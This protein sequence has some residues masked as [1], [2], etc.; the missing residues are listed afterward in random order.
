MWNV[1]STRDFA[2]AAPVRCES[3]DDARSVGAGHVAVDPL[4]ARTIDTTIEVFHGGQWVAAHPRSALKRRHARTQH[5]HGCCPLPP[6]SD[7][8]RRPRSG[9]PCRPSHTPSRNLRGCT[10]HSVAGRPGDV[11]FDNLALAPDVCRHGD[12]ETTRPLSCSVRYACGAGTDRLATARQLPPS[13]RPHC[14]SY[15]CA[16]Q[17]TRSR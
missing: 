12:Y 1:E 11:Q 3:A 6:R 10:R 15:R 8:A 17:M 2:A 9:R 14:V 16:Q 13:R 5:E 7:R 4:K